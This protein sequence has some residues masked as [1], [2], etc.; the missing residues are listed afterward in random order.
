VICQIRRRKNIS[1]DIKLNSGVSCS[2]FI[3]SFLE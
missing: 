2:G 3:F 1:A